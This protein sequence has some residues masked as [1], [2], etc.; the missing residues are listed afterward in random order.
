MRLIHYFSSKTLRISF[1]YTV[2]LDKSNSSLPLLT[3]LITFYISFTSYEHT[4][5]TKYLI[6]GVSLCTLNILITLSEKK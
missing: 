2:V 4:G 5:S 1:E 6:P 3:S